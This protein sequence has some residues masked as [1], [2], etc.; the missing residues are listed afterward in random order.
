ME[1]GKEYKTGIYMELKIA[2]IY[3]KD[4]SNAN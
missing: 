2:K 4:L 3:L 1:I